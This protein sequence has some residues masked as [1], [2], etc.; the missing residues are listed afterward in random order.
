M[1]KKMDFTKDQKNAVKS[2]GGTL[3]VSAAAGSGKTAVLTHRVK[4]LLSDETEDISPQELLIVTYT[5]AAAA[6]MRNKIADELRLNVAQ[7]GDY[8]VK[9]Q[10]LLLPCADICTMDSFCS[11]LVRENF[12]LADVQPDFRILS[13]QEE[14]GFQQ[15]AANEVL[16]QLYKND[17]GDISLLLDLFL[18]EK[19]DSPLFDAVI[20]LYKYSQSYPFPKKWLLSLI[21]MYD[22]YKPLSETQWGGIILKY[23]EQAVDYAVYLSQE[24]LKTA[25][26]DEKLFNNYSPAI[27][28]D[29]SQLKKIKQLIQLRDW[30]CV[31]TALRDFS[32]I[33]LGSGTKEAEPD[34]K[35]RAK[36]QRDKVKNVIN[37]FL[38]YQL[39]LQYEHSEDV[40]A[41]KGAIE[42]L[43]N[44]VMSF[45]EKL[46]EMK[47][48][49]NSYSFSDI[50]HKSI[51][52]LVD[53][54]GGKTKLSKAL[55]EK[56][57]EILIDEYQDTNEAQ[58]ML[59]YA[60]SREGGNLFFV[61]DVKQSIYGFRQAMPEIF[62]RKKES[63]PM[64]DGK[65][66][67][68]QIML[69][70]NFRSRKAVCECVNHVFSRIMSMQTGGLQY[71]NGERLVAAAHYPPA[72]T[73]EVELIMLSAPNETNTADL[74]T[75]EAE[76]VAD[77]I[78][79]AVKSG[80]CIKEKDAQRPVRYGDFC[81]LL[82]TVKD[83]AALYYNSLK[84]RDIPVTFAKDSSFFSTREISFIHS[85]LRVIDNPLLDVPLAGVLM[86]PVFGFTADDL[87][88][89][90]IS[91]REEPLFIGLCERADA[92][93]E[94]ASL[95]LE[96]FT[97]FRNEASRLDVVETLFYL[98]DETGIFSVISAMD[99]AQ[100]R[101]RNLLALLNLAKQYSER[102]EYSIG[103]FT[104][105]L[106]KIAASGKGIEHSGTGDLSEHEV[107]IMSI[108]K[109]KGLEFPVVI[110]ADCT[111]KFNQS[112]TR[113]SLP[114]NR[115]AGIGIVRRDIDTL[116]KY[117][118]VSLSATRLCIEE[119]E[120][121]EEL[122]LLYVA[123]TRA[124]EKLVMIC[125]KT[126]KDDLAFID[127][128]IDE[129]GSVYPFAVRIAKSYYEWLTAALINHPDADVLRRTKKTQTIEISNSDFSLK[130]TT[131]KLCKNEIPEK[132]YEFV[133][134]PDEQMTELIVER[135]S[136]VYPYM[137]LK[138]V[139]AKRTASS[140][141]HDAAAVQFFAQSKP[142]FVPGQIN[143]AEKGT[144]VHRF[145]EV[146]DLNATA[147][148]AEGEAEKL[149]K[150]G[151]LSNE[152][153]Q[154]IDFS[155]VNSFF[156]SNLGKRL[157]LA[158]SVLREYKFS[159][160]R[161][162]GEL[163]EELDEAAANEQIVVEGI[164]DCAFYEGDKLI[165]I[166]YKTDKTDNFGTFKLRYGKQLEIY[167]NALAQCEGK[168]VDQAYIYSLYLSSEIEM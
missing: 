119:T 111:N 6:E 45:Y 115:K 59:F 97:R 146:C 95:F 13:E 125:S 60:I 66:F 126:E 80:F 114:I 113:D 11:K 79:N 24:A 145:L 2:K 51:D 102:R 168:S 4:R 139:F 19:G 35:E 149:L 160:F 43:V 32:F 153:Y 38:D 109:S 34:L 88:R 142:S 53:A 15:A 17:E 124:R 30:D 148:N 74:V 127:N 117:K 54:K 107:K 144:A 36:N 44:T 98:F 75:L 84:K 147:E 46:D 58:D 118:T 165:L 10:L 85:L 55:S 56:Y 37:S 122:R 93:D 72:C 91:R 73:N 57:K 99:H 29:I 135:I 86:F 70:R 131:D 106:N 89:I 141:A 158:S 90:R 9:K 121:A 26:K 39:P 78:E 62:L 25:S 68:S 42:L 136:Y 61:G 7:T 152:E 92:G 83:K 87:A 166:D 82:R 1:T 110:I 18:N 12:H 77:Y 20:K 96:T 128:M 167:K 47:K 104:M 41:L 27:K 69:D 23:I 140:F 150:D 120:K 64:Y 71:D 50:L 14:I 31:V 40:L 101:R 157:V 5:R 33:N 163:Y 8:R 100:D 154:L 105:F 22:P 155:K 133:S 123:M 156:D 164:I 67:P 48:Q 94:K 49:E 52:L 108:H 112:F 16:E 138:E 161:S 28:N 116:S 21:E 130:I 81:I 63:L 159:V 134:K 143:A 162:A 132:S 151:I 3:F 137:S 65:V 103:S 129:K 76:Y